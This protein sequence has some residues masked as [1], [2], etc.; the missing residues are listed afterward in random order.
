MI[1]TLKSYQTDFQSA[2]EIFNPQFFFSKALSIEIEIGSGKGSFL[3][4]SAL[5]NPDR[6]YL[7]IESAHVYARVAEARARRRNAS[8]VRILDWSAELLLPFFKAQSVDR[9]HVYFPD[10][11][12]KKRHQKRRLW[13][14]EIL[15]HMDRVLNPDGKIYFATDHI[16]Y[17]AH[18]LEL[19]E[20]AGSP[21]DCEHQERYRFFQDA[22]LATSY[23]KKFQ[24]EGR[25]MQYAS[26]VKRGQVE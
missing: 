19:I 22:K 13:N 7:G 20:Q 1:D 2:S 26:F 3:V 16:S 23:E 5:Q 18:V 12:P 21:F 9:F 11:W 10:P 6:Y 24:S 25:P 15:I 4:E 17:F 14:H 8:N